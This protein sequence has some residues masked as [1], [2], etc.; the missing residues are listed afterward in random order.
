MTEKESKRDKEKERVTKERTTPKRPYV[1]AW[2]C[3]GPTT[4]SE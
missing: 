4:T 1:V 2:C 3:W